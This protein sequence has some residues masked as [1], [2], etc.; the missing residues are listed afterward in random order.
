MIR[1]GWTLL[2]TLKVCVKFFD[3]T[4][5]GCPFSSYQMCKYIRHDEEGTA[6]SWVL[7]TLSVCMRWYRRCKRGTCGFVS[8]NVINVERR[9]SSPCH[10]DHVINS[11][12][13]VHPP[14]HWKL[15]WGSKITLISVYINMIFDWICTLLENKW[16]HHP[17]PIPCSISD[18]VSAS[19]GGGERWQWCWWA[20]KCQGQVLHFVIFIPVS[21]KTVHYYLRL[22][23]HTWLR[24]SLPVESLTTDLAAALK[25]IPT[26]YQVILTTNIRDTMVSGSARYI[27]K[28]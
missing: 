20:E 5:M 13:G 18:C 6:P 8:A 28:S 19:W 21:V 16:K 22:S 11:E 15:A 12:K 7:V 27:S 17:F 23:H 26:E 3:A 24:F 9:W 2:V 1:R 14:Q 10:I 25:L 4:S